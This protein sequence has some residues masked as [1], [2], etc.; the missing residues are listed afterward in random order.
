ME[1]KENLT[2]GYIYDAFKYL[3]RQKKYDDISVCDITE[4]AGVS[5]MSFYRNFKSKEDLLYQGIDVIFSNLR[6]KFVACENKNI[7]TVTKL[8]FETFKGYKTELFSLS[9]SKVTQAILDTVPEKLKENTDD[10]YMNKTSKYIPIFYY[11]AIT[12]V[13]FDWLKNGTEEPP[14]E[15]AKMISGLINFDIHD[16]SLV[17]E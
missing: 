9:N 7:Y 4:K 8:I 6:K 17:A 5:R 10:D 11:G 12:T 16:E 2:K 13:L 14:E 15:M 1:E 3:L